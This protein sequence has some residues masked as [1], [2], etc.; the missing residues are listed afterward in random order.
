MSFSNLDFLTQPM[1]FKAGRVSSYDKTGGN[2][3]AWPI[4]AGETKVIAELEGPGAIS[5][6][7]FTIASTDKF[8]LRKI[9]LKIYRD[10]E[11]EPSVCSPVGD[12][13]GLGH[14]RSYTYQNAA[15]STSCNEDGKLGEGVA[16]N[17]WLPMPYK[18]SARIEAVNEQKEAIP[19]FYFYID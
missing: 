18:K 6:I 16:M 9:L 10:D 7:W 14:S 11:D 2:Y 5:H 3:D 13:F 12:F 15:F 4:E 8:Y 19:S 17:C 1:P